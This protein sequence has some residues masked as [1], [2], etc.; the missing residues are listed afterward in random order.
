MKKSIKVINEYAALDTDMVNKAWEA[1]RLGFNHQ[2]VVL[3]DDPT[4]IQTVHGI[5]VYT[6][7]S[8]MSIEQGFTENNQIFFILTNSRAFSAEKTKQVHREIAERVAKAAE[9]HNVSF[10]LINRSDSTLRG[11]YPLETEVLYQTLKKRGHRV[12]GE[13]I[14]PFF[15]EGGRLTIEGIHYVCS[16]NKLTPAGETEFARDRTFGY[17][18]S[19]LAKYVE[20]KTEGRY[21][22]NSV[23]HIPLEM[24]RRFDVDGIT[25]KLMKVGHFNKVIVDALEEQDVKVFSLALIRALKQGKWFLYR[26]AAT[27]TKVIGDVSS[28]P[29]LQATELVDSAS[30]KGGLIMIG[31]HVQKTTD[32]L[33]ALQTLDSLHFIEMNTHLVLDPEMFQK[34]TTRVQEEAEKHVAKG[35]STV[36]Y[37]KREYLKLR[38]ELKE[39][40]LQISVE[41]SKA[42][43]SI[44]AN[45]AERPR[46][47]IAK[48]GITSSDIGTNGL[49]VRRATVAGQ[50]SPGVPVWKTGT[51]SKFPNLPYIIFPGNVGSVSTF[52]DIV[53]LL[54]KN[55]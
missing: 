37:T 51:E 3:D 23:T 2:I 48:G 21:P 24:I 4:G 16:D 26:T 41:I 8:E 7:W 50:V 38:D 13:I 31:S 18:A 28:R 27:F 46:Y 54:E 11:H 15:Y 10:L 29:L 20:E 45:F 32:Q 6:D 34:E 39:K 17:Q 40:E 25:A 43:T 33:K 14:L 53:I 1:E 42:V 36:I 5:S 30:A 52:K 35:V 22:A 55:K 19:H 44:V 47:L 49:R 12:D 9:K